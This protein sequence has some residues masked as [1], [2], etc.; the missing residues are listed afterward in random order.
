MRKDPVNE[1]SEVKSLMLSRE[2]EDL[3]R[4]V[5]LPFQHFTIIKEGI[6]RENLRLGSLSKNLVF[7]MFKIDQSIVESIFDLL[8]EEEEIILQEIEA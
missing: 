4:R 6:L 1:K 2:E 7:K 5:G 8:V 3:S